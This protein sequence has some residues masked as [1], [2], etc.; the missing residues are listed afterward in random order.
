MGRGMWE[1]ATRWVIPESVFVVSAVVVPFLL[2]A[3]YWAQTR[4]MILAESIAGITAFREAVA[5]LTFA[6]FVATLSQPQNPAYAAPV[7][8][9]FAMYPL[10]RMGGLRTWTLLVAIA[11]ATAM[12][13]AHHGGPPLSHASPS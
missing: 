7:V 12:L 8:V 5:V 10:G 13:L 2:G 11:A 6:I 1:L 9:G 3:A 4:R